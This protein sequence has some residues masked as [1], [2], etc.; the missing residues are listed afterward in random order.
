MKKK[1]IFA[2]LLIAGALFLSGCDASN[3]TIGAIMGASV[4]T[5]LSLAGTLI[6]LIRGAN[7]TKK[8]ALIGIVAGVVVIGGIT[9]AI[10]GYTMDEQLKT[11]LEKIQG[12][13]VESGNDGQAIKVTFES[14][15]H[16]D[17]GKSDLN[18]TFKSALTHFAAS[19]NG[20]PDTDVHIYGHTDSNENDEE[21]NVNNSLSLLR[22]QMVGNF[23]ISQGVAENRITTQGMGSSEPVADNETEAGRAQNRRVEIYIVPNA[24]MIRKAE[25]GILE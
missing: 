12:A 21:D 6:L 22:A 13:Q 23:L 11:E 16:F 8:G 10:I 9:G 20:T 5:A 19:L 14:G 17:I 1:I 4:G 3:T 24:E 25:A 18:S 2:S 7:N 15:N